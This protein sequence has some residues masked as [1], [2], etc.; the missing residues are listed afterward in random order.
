MYYTG[1]VSLFTIII[2][3]KAANNKMKTIINKKYLT[4]A[5]YFNNIFLYYTSNAFYT[6]QVQNEHMTLP[7]MSQY[8]SQS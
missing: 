4:P 1:L 6:V 3:Y 8:L 7:F 5:A 2:G